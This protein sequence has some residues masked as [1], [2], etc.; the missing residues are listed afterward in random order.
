MVG[1]GWVGLILGAHLHPRWDEILFAIC[2]P[3]VVL[4][5][6]TIGT[7]VLAWIKLWLPLRWRGLLRPKNEVPDAP[8]YLYLVTEDLQE[9]L[10]TSHSV[11]L[12]LHE[13]ELR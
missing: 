3:C 13:D 5:P 11:L 10:R 2:L 7:F 6:Y 1:L 12:E 4:I 9:L 8:L